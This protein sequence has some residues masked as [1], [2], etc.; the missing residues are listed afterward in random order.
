MR[1][2]AHFFG[3]PVHP[4][5][6]HI[7]IGLWLFSLAADLIGPRSGAP[8]TWA[9]IALYTMVA[10][11]LSAV[12]AGVPGLMD[13]YALADRPIRRVAF[14]H[15]GFN[16]LAI[17][18]YSLDAVARTSALVGSAVPLALSLAG[19]ATLAVAGWLGGKMVYEAGVGVHDGARHDADRG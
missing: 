4:M 10:G 15:M 19:I 13:L 16:L 11:I 17:L 5:L 8:G 7:P 2:A 3:H 18:L 12:A 9:D 1:S 6:V 14:A